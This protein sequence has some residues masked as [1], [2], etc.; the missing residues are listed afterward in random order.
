MEREE[1][2]GLQYMNVV[3]SDAQKIVQ[4]PPKRKVVQ[5]KEIKKEIEEV[6]SSIVMMP[7]KTRIGKNPQKTSSYFVTTDEPVKKR[8]LRKII[9]PS[10]IAEEEDEA[11][12]SLVRTIKVADVGTH[13]VV[14]ES[15]HKGAQLTVYALLEQSEK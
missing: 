13:K 15:I 4:K 14:E 1:A 11:G 7:S 6:V 5:Q 8:E 2:S 3:A 9:L 10:K 12:V